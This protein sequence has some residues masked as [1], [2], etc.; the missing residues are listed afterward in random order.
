MICAPPISL[1]ASLPARQAIGKNVISLHRKA[2]HYQA[3]MPHAWFEMAGNFGYHLGQLDSA[4]P[5]ANLALEASPDWVIVAATMGD[6]YQTRGE[7]D[8]A[9]EWLDRGIAINRES[10]PL[11]ILLSNLCKTPRILQHN[12]IYPTC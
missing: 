10:V 7:N 6:L 1:P 12:I 11:L 2:L 5:Y 3:E 4:E 8:K 9:K